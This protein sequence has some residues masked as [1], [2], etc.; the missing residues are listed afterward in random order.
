MIAFGLASIGVRY[1]IEKYP[2]QKTT[3]NHWINHSQLYCGVAIAQFAL[4]LLAYKLGP[5]AT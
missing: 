3:L 1:P 5:P 2:T 4:A